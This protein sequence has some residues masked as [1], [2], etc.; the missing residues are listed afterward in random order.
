MASDRIYRSLARRPLLTALI[1]YSIT[2]AALAGAL[3]RG[4]VEVPPP[5]PPCRGLETARFFA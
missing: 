3:W 4:T 1:V 5:S 2:Y